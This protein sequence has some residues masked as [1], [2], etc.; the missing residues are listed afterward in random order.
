MSML[1]EKINLDGPDFNH[2]LVEPRFER[3]LG[4]EYAMS[5]P[6]F[7]HQSILLAIGIQL[8]EKLQASACTPIIA[9]FDVYPFYD[10]NDKTTLVQPDILL[11]CDK[12][13]LKEKSYNGAPKFIIE[14]LSPSNPYH[15]TLTKLQLYEKAGVSEYWIVNP[16]EQTISVFVLVES[17]PNLKELPEHL[18]IAKWDSKYI[19]RDY[20]GEDEVPLVTIPGCTIDFKRIF[21]F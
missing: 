17:S 8:K 1:A 12:S 13:K 20:S 7:K 6:G 19:C 15:D 11:A 4:T 18:K 16:E 5:S 9:P 14:I 21:A 2:S 3:I 10:K